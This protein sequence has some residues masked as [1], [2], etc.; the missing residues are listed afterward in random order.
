MAAGLAPKTLREGTMETIKKQIRVRAGVDRSV[1]GIYTPT[2]TIEI[3]GDGDDAGFEIEAEERLAEL[4]RLLEQRY[5][6][7]AS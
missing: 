6:F 1:K 2:A 3:T 7:D 5:P 4:I